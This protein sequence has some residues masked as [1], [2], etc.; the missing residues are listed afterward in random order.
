L[1]AI[2][3]TSVAQPPINKL[4]AL[5]VMRGV[6]SDDRRL[7]EIE[8][9]YRSGFFRF[10]RVAIAITGDYQL[11]LEAV[12][13]GFADVIR[14]RSS[15]RGEGPLEGWVWRAVVNAG[16]DSRRSRRESQVFDEPATHEGELPTT[17]TELRAAIAALPER[18]R[19]ALFLRH[20]ADLDYRAIGT[21]LGIKTGTVSATLSA[22]HSSLRK[23]LS[24]VE[25]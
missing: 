22:A 10:L 7:A 15:F 20:Y 17:A 19:L 16:R 25:S 14:S 21:A 5:P 24:G 12:Q 8:Q 4:G 9:L 6:A 18:Q 23:T 13:D 2:G 1:D 11:G 3:K